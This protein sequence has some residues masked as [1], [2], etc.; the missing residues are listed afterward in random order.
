MPV[1]LKLKKVSILNATVNDIDENKNNYEFIELDSAQIARQLDELDAAAINTNFA[2]EFGLSPTKDSIFIEPKDSPFANLIAVR[3][4]SKD[5]EVVQQFIDLYRSE[6]V[7][8]IH[9]RNI[10]WIYYSFLVTIFA[11]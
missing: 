5:E 2:I 4:E 7:E 11:S 10:R 6:E 1:L 3:T 8:E 9:R